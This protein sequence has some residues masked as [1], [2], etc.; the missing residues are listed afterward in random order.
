MSRYI[1]HFNALP[2][3]LLSGPSTLFFVWTGLTSKLLQ[4]QN[5]Y[6]MIVLCIYTQCNFE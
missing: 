2:Q 1:N 5:Y 4:K 6:I 3:K